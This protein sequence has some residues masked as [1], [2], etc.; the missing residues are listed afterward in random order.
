MNAKNDLVRGAIWASEL[1][2]SEIDRAMR[3]ISERAVPKGGYLFHRGYRFDYWTGVISGLFKMSTV[4]AS[5]KAMTFAGLGPGSWFGE[6]SVLKDEPRKY[7][8]VALRDSQIAVMTRTTFDWL[9]ANSVGFNRFLVRQLN[10]RLGQFIAV[11]ENDRI[12][13]PK[14]KVARNL[15]WLFNPVLYPGIE[16]RIDL[17]QEEL[18]LLAGVSRPVASKCLQSLE[19]EGLIRQEHG[20]ITVLD[21]EALREY[22][23][24]G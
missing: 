19:E 22:E 17:S 20:R 6:G 13:E 8:V 16:P 5:G 11:M 21:V 23:S 12:L 18:A 9:C 24:R 2:E 1:S 4:S 15:S 14:A 10:E 3:G 7:D